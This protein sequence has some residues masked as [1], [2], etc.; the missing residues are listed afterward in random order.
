MEAKGHIDDGA[1]CSYSINEVNPNSPPIFE[2]RYHDGIRVN[3]SSLETLNN[4]AGSTLELEW[5]D[6]NNVPFIIASSEQNPSSPVIQPMIVSSNPPEDWMHA[7]YDRI[8]CLS[9]REICMPGTH[10]SGMSVFGG[11]SGFGLPVNTKT[12]ELGLKDQLQF[13]ARWFDIRPVIAGGDWTTGHYSFGAG[14]W[15]GGNG[16]YI[17]PM[18]DRINE[19]TASNKELV[20]LKLSHGLNTDNFYADKNN[21]LSQV[22]WDQLMTLM[23]GITD[24]VTGRGATPDLSKLLVSDLIADRAAVIVVI[25]DVVDSYGTPVDVSVFADQGFFRP[26]QLPL[27]DEYANKSD[28]DKMIDNQLG[29]LTLQRQSRGSEMFLLSWTLT[30]LGLSVIENGKAVNRALAEKLWPVMTIDTYPNI[31]SVDAYPA[32]RDIAA[33]SMA[34][35]YHFAQMC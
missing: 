1:E 22:E 6:D 11:G 20:I 30:Q 28:Q 5:H 27:F 23:E 19:F 29:K 31:I 17:A 18:V 14:E 2:V 8:S 15:Q 34:I 25:D 26:D 32:N 33:L 4:F 7:T 3:F 12:Q 10:D 35:N 21:H 16:E 9:L 13:G 24:R